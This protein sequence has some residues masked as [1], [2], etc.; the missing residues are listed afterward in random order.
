MCIEIDFSEKSLVIRKMFLAC[1]DLEKLNKMKVC[2]TIVK[3]FLKNES[4]RSLN[5]N[6]KDKSV[7]KKFSENFKKLEKQSEK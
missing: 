4:K 3:N 1:K 7:Q 6:L 2:T 5:L